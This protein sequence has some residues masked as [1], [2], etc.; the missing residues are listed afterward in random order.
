MKQLPRPASPAP[1]VMTARELADHLRIHPSTIYRLL[2]TGKLPG[3]R[4]GADWRFNREHI[5]QIELRCR[6]LK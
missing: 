5:Q 2:K 6:G 4:I 1:A 3:F